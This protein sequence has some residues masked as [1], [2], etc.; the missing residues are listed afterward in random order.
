MFRIIGL[1][2]RD[3]RF[4]TGRCGARCR[5]LDVSE[6][7][8]RYGAPIVPTETVLGGLVEAAPD[9]IVVCDADERVVMVNRQ[10]ER[11]FGYRRSALLGT[12]VDSL[13]PPAPPPSARR[14]RT[15]PFP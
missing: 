12:Y 8:A 3:Q 7:G 15:R 6:G 5:C 13:L 11:L 10:A 9:A 2:S 14:A 1:I 4:V